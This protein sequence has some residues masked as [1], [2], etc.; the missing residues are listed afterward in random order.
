[1]SHPEE[2]YFRM[3]LPVND[4]P[5]KTLSEIMDIIKEER[6]ILEEFEKESAREY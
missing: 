3:G 6:K 5:P 2:D 1:M 4:D